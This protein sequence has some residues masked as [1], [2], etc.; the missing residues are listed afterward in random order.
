M[1]SNKHYTKWLLSG[2][3]IFLAEGFDYKEQERIIIQR[4]QGAAKRRGLKLAWKRVFN[5]PGFIFQGYQNNHQPPVL[6]EPTQKT[7]KK[8][9]PFMY[10]RSF[11][12]DV[13]LKPSN[14]SEFCENHT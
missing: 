5:P 6:S 11:G 13:K 8:N 12:C 1:F 2:R 4:L 14:D 3:Q 7:T 10:C 9:Y